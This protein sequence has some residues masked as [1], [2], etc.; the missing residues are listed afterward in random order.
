MT[1]E[2][3]ARAVAKYF[4]KLSPAVRAEIQR[5][6]ASAIRRA[7]KEQLA[8]LEIE[9]QGKVDGAKGYGKQGK[10]RDPSAIHFHSQWARPFRELRTG[11]AQPDPLDLSMLPPPHS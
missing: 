10:F 8:K 1:P 5:V 11:K 3:R 7:V 9:A 6:V 4:A 2:E